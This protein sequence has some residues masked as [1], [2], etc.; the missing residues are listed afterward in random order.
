MFVV[1]E[2]KS[3]VY[4]GKVTLP[5][6]YQLKKKKIVGKWKDRNTLYLSDSQSALNYTAGKEGTVFDAVIDTNERLRVPPEYEKGRVKIKG[7]ISTVR[8][9]FEV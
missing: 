4:N 3:E 1:G 9:L 8:L 2:M 6:E 5:K 7:C